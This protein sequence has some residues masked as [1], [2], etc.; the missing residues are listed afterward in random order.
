MM[1]LL[2]SS[3]FYRLQLFSVYRRLDSG[4]IPY[5]CKSIPL[6]PH[7]H[8][9]SNMTL[10]HFTH[11]LNPSFQSQAPASCLSWSFSIFLVS[12]VAPCPSYYLFHLTTLFSPSL[13]TSPPL[14]HPPLSPSTF[15]RSKWKR[16]ARI[17]QT[18]KLPKTPPPPLHKS[19]SPPFFLSWAG[20]SWDMS[21]GNWLH[22]RT[23]CLGSDYCIRRDSW[24]RFTL[25]G[26]DI[27]Y[28]LHTC[29]S[30]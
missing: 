9:S 4:F 22:Y 18:I 27:L 12:H 23:C 29:T 13:S 15:L 19:I 10:P 1:C 30:I 14:Q 25:I 28:G 17:P 5:V 7:L 26:G 21:E 20:N 11:Q 3:T 24:S 2:I 16:A 8:L 6:L